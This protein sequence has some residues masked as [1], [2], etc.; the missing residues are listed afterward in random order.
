MLKKIFH[1]QK[2]L[3]KCINV[4][5]EAQARCIISNPDPNIG[6]KFI[7]PNIDDK[8]ENKVCNE[9]YDKCLNECYMPHMVPI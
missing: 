5:N 7:N 3:E 9:A 1:H 4:C 6:T 8:T 2:T